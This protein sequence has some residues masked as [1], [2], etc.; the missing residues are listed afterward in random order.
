MGL[1]KKKKIFFRDIFL[2]KTYSIVLAVWLLELSEV[3]RKI[4]NK[5][6]HF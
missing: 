5:T 3:N 6:T 4:Y 2:E 1:Q